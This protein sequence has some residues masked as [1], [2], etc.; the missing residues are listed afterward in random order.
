MAAVRRGNTVV[1]ARLG[2]RCGSTPADVDILSAE[3]V[4][5][6]MHPLFPV[7][8]GVLLGCVGIHVRIA[9]DVSRSVS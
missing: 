5:T 2:C 7:R 8:I 9:W 6:A 3:I 1:V 4:G